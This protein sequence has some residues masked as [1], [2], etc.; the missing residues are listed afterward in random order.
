MRRDGL[1]IEGPEPIHVNQVHATDDPHEIGLADV[2]MLCVKL[3]DTEEA[4]EQI[5]RW[6][7]PTPPLSRSRTAC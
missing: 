5:R 4:I 7:D 1:R 3:W 6:S 2:V